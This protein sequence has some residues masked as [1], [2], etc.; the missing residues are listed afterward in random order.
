MIQFPH[1]PWQKHLVNIY[2][3][4]VLVLI[5][6]V[7]RLIEYAMGMDAYL[8]TNEWPTYVFDTLLMIIVMVAF[9]VIHPSEVKALLAGR[10]LV[11]SKVILTRHVTLSRSERGEELLGREPKSLS[12]SDNQSFRV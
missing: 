1:L 3:A 10:G 7:F 9:A 6:C 8:Y 4:S 11:M 2:A 12:A 5:R